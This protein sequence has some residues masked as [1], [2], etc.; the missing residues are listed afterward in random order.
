[1][2]E[3]LTKAQVLALIEERH[4]ALTAVLAGARDEELVRAG[5]ME[6]WS[7]KDIL[8][9]ITWWEGWML[10]ILR[11]DVEATAELAMMIGVEGD[12]L[13]D[14]MNAATFAAQR[15]RALV[16]VRVA[17]DASYQAAKRA[18]ADLP[19]ET[20]A[21]YQRIVA[22]NTWEHYEEH[23]PMVRAWRERQHA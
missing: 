2:A 21:R 15:D 23:T 9:H 4:A 13:I 18:V 17:F 7:I 19:D 12:A 8:A 11:G 5:A 22:A 14:R 10:R 3:T 1:M 20:L 6:G 16:E